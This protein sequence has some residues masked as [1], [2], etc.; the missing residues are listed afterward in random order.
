[1]QV[2]ARR[3]RCDD[4][5]RCPICGEVVATSET[6]R[7]F[8]KEA[9]ELEE[10]FIKLKSEF[11][12]VDLKSEVCKEKEQN[13]EGRYEVYAR[14]KSNRENRLKAKLVYWKTF[15]EPCSSYTAAKNDEDTVSDALTCPPPPTSHSSLDPSCC[16]HL[17]YF[18][19][20]HH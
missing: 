3:K 7:H 14:I 4:A 18:S 10:Q 1:M 15:H 12:A 5:D 11:G 2:R 9:A 16:C 19:N 13:I 17:S 8:A 6:S 20:A